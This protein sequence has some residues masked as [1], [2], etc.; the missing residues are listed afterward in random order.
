MNSGGNRSPFID[1]DGNRMVITINGIK[2]PGCYMSLTF[3][4]R[5]LEMPRNSDV[6]TGLM[7]FQEF[8]E[9]ISTVFPDI[10]EMDFS[11][12]MEMYESIGI[13]LEQL[14]DNQR[15]DG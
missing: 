2:C 6:I 8:K 1:N 10:Q 4:N 5:C 14:H 12:F 7:N 11:K 9:S 15:V 3:C 13:G